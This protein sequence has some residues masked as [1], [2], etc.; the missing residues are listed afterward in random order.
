MDWQFAVIA[1]IVTFAFFT[2]AATGFGAVVIA[3]TFG[4]F[5]Y[6]VNVLLTWFI[7]QVLL[8]SAYMLIKHHDH[9]DWNLLLKVILPFMGGGLVL[10]QVIYYAADTQLLTLL[11][12]V[13]VAALSLRALFVKPKTDKAGPFWPWALSAGVVHGIIATGGPI[14]VFGLNQQKLDKAAFRSTLLVVWLVM[15]VVL[16]SSFIISGQLTK[17]SLPQIGWLALCIPVSIVLGEYA[18][19]RMNAELFQRIINVILLFCGMALLIKAVPY[20]L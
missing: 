6:P 19:K 17:E 11:L 16:I 7:P 4:A 3:L 2:Q 12:G 15:G 13:V 18:H 10:G 1:L 20:Y 14:L 9:I 8:L 5:F